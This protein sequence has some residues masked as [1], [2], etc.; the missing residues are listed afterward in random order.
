M[1]QEYYSKLDKD[2]PHFCK[3]YIIVEEKIKNNIFSGTN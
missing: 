2:G 1:H 3:A